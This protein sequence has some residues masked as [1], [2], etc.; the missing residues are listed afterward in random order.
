M[1]K[2]QIAYQELQERKRANRASEELTRIRDSNTYEIGLGTLEESKRHNLAFEMETNRHNRIVETQALESLGISA[3]QATVA[4]R[5]A[6]TNEKMAGI[7]QYDAETRR[8]SQQEQARHNRAA[9]SAQYA[10]LAELVR[11]NQA[12]ESLT[13]RQIIELNRHNL[14]TEANQSKE[15]DLQADRNLISKYEAQLKS[16]VAQWDIALKHAQI[17]LTNNQANKVEAETDYLGQKNI[18][19]WIGVGTDVV[20]AGSNALRSVGS[21]V[22]NVVGAF[23]P[24]FF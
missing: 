2:N 12:S 1:T 9:I 6:A 21:F 13:D 18:R 8:L 22:N 16:D 24:N 4:E 15:L 23:A 17:D 20:N 19:D 3:R 11:H 7:S 14:K 10:Q 5:N